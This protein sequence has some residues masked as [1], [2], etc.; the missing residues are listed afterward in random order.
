MMK[1]TVF[2]IAIIA[3]L[4][5]CAPAQLDATSIPATTTASPRPTA[6]MTATP[7]LAA[8]WIDRAVPELLRIAAEESGIPLAESPES[9]TLHLGVSDAA[10]ASVWTYALAA[11]F[12]TVQDGIS[13]K[14]LRALW[15]GDAGGAVWMAD[16]TKAALT[17]LWGEASPKH[18][19]TAPANL[20]LDFAWNQGD[21]FVIIPF[22]ELEPRWKA[23]T[24]DGQS[25]LHND[26]VVDEYPLQ[27]SF[28]VD[29]PV[30][31]DLPASNRDPDKL[32]VLV[33]TGVT[34]LVRATAYTMEHKGITYPA[35]SIGVWLR[36]ADIT[37]ISN[38]IPFYPECKPPTPGQI[39]LQFCSDPRY[40]EL[41]EFV[42]AD[43]V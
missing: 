4:A 41:L 42:S 43:V 14:E 36:N 26:F 35:Q 34:A 15:R 38:E 39:G 29:A 5:A 22:E 27:L 18:V 21:I 31:L 7:R 2:T 8:L 10:D 17:A 32:T 30:S 28:G 24:I 13:S 40:I 19:R 6:T 1:K 37:H 23:L 3:L 20:L 33:M 25:P 16:S 9:A 12:P 11:P